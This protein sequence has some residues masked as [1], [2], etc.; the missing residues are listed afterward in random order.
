MPRAVEEAN[1]DIL[2]LTEADGRF[3]PDYPIESNLT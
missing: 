1:A 2:V 3:V